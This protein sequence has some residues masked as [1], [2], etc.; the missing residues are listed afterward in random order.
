MFWPLPISP[1]TLVAST[2]SSIRAYFLSARPVI[3]SLTP[4]EYTSAVSKKLMPASTARLKNGCASSSSSTQSRHFFE[5]YDMQPRQMRET[6]RPVEPRKANFK[7]SPVLPRKRRRATER[8][9][10]AAALAYPR[11]ACRAPRLT[12]PPAPRPS[13]RRGRARGCARGRPRPQQPRLHGPAHRPAGSPTPS[14]RAGLR[15]TPTMPS[16]PHIHGEDLVAIVSKGDGPSAAA[17]NPKPPREARRRP[18]SNLE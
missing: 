1:W 17:L 14:C 16:H 15:N 10:I 6:R 3:S 11:P 7:S 13:P 9:S 2:T 4:T 12:S 8:R 18:V 5:P